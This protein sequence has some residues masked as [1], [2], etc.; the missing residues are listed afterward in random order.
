MLLGW[1]AQAA[2]ARP[3]RRVILKL[4]GTT[5]EAQTHSERYPFDVMLAGLDDRPDNL[6]VSTGPMSQHLTRAAAL[7]TVSSTPP[8]RPSRW[9]CRFSRSTISESVAR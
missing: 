6:V 1:L 9:T 2:R 8:S 3:D 4:R 7:V 5:G